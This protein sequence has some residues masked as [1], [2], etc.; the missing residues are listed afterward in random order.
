MITADKDFGEL[1]FKQECIM[2]NSHNDFEL[3]PEYD[4]SKG[5]RGRFYTP[6]KVSIT[7]RL[8]DDILLYFKK[9]AGIK[10]QVIKLY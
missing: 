1:I 5:I 8:D 6:K 10:K 3:Q 7:I 4:F 2:N 9:L